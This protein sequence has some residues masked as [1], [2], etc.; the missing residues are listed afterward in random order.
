MD[1]VIKPTAEELAEEQ[2]G[3]QVLK[4]EEVRDKVISDFG[5]DP[6]A[7]KEKIDKMVSREI[8][9]SKK[10]SKTIGQKIKYRDSVGKIPKDT[11]NN[12]VEPQKVEEGLSDS[13]FYALMN[14]KVP[15]EDLDDVKK[16]AKLLGKSIRESLT[17]PVVKTILAR[18]AE[19]R[20]TAEAANTNTSRRTTS[21]PNAAVLLE[22]LKKGE[23]PEKGTEAADDLFWARRGGK[24]G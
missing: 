7:D 12:T 6:E 4:E 1:D 22:N 11:K 3:S 15:E 17:D 10:L 21:K 14:A 2:V 20:A 9:H 23:V 8:D 19:E 5:F 13:D 16:S 18:K 24:K